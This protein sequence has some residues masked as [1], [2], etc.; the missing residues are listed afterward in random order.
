MDQE[1]EGF[2]SELEVG[3]AGLFPVLRCSLMEGI[4]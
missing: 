4:D 2:F 1:G 3:K